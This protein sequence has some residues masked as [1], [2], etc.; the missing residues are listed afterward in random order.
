MSVRLFLVFFIFVTAYSPAMAQGHNQNQ[1]QNWVDTILNELRKAGAVNVSRGPVAYD[2][3]SGAFSVTDLKAE[4]PQTTS[5]KPDINED[6]KG[7]FRKNGDGKTK[8]TAK[9]RK[10]AVTIARVSA[11]GLGVNGASWT[12][13][14]LRVEGVQVTAK[15]RQGALSIE[16]VE[17]NVIDA[18][19]IE[20]VAFANPLEQIVTLI[21]EV[22]F[23]R[24]EI[25]KAVLSGDSKNIE[26]TQFGFGNTV[27]ET[28]VKG[29]ARLLAIDE[30]SGLLAAAEEEGNKD[31]KSK[32]ENIKVTLGKTAIHDFDL[33]LYADLFRAKPKRAGQ[34]D[35][36]LYSA[37]EFDGIAAEAEKS[38]SFKLRPVTAKN[39]RMS[40]PE[41]GFKALYDLAVKLR[42]TDEIP[43]ESEEEFYN[44]YRSWISLNNTESL[45]SEGFEFKSDNAQVDLKSVSGENIGASIGVLSLQNFSLA[46]PELKVGFDSINMKNVNTSIF[47]NALLEEMA[48]DKDAPDYSKLEGKL[49][50]FDLIELNALTLQSAGEQP[51]LISRLAFEL[52]SWARWVPERFRAQLQKAVIP[53]DALKDIGK[54]DLKDLE[55][56]QLEV[57]SDLQFALDKTAKTAV[58]APFILDLGEAGKISSELRLS[59]ITDAMLGAS[60][61]GD[62]ITKL[63]EARFDGLNITIVNGNVLERFYNWRMKA[64]K[65]SMEAVKADLTSS[66]KALALI[67]PDNAQQKKANEAVDSF[68]AGKKNLVIVIKPKSAL[69]LLDLQLGLM[70]NQDGLLKKVDFDVTA[71]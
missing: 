61:F 44:F 18:P 11:D 57:S 38:F 66:L 3:A 63:A 68:V 19:Y 23:N 71:N 59:N 6:I 5:A 70:A 35:Q 34:K 27:I 26:T 42:S 29:K 49:P 62:D 20:A 60:A 37:A 41:K 54:P 16:R 7:S 33:G 69:S 45:E 32:P 43:K 17:F 1:I 10:I 40:V 48:R 30:G 64:A 24:G 4:F 67:I 12:A 55:Y 13:N 51:L 15:D 65:I 53:A 14:A 8:T 39:G 21:Q 56:K 46:S 50:T 47:Y 31:D 22:S 28:Y 36:L 2:K 52:S 58:L 9:D 25:I